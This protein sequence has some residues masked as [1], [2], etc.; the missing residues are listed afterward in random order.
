MGKL[1]TTADAPASV[2]GMQAA[3]SCLLRHFVMDVM[4]DKVHCQAEA[5]EPKPS[6][7]RSVG[8]KWPQLHCRLSSMAKVDRAYLHLPNQHDPLSKLLASPLI[9]PS[10]PVPC[11]IPLP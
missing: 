10:I 5:H 9:A 1:A 8:P 4:A 11:R 3:D 2:V 7:L 6:C